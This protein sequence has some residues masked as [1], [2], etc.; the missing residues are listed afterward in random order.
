M[1]VPGLARP[2]QHQ[3]RASD[4]TKARRTAQQGDHVVRGQ[5]VAE[6]VLA[7]TRLPPGR[8]AREHPSLP[9]R[10]AFLEQV[11]HTTPLDQL[12]GSRGE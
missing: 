3:Q 10:V 12:H 1:G 8:E 2:R 4:E 6:R 11:Q 5:G 7:G 9:E